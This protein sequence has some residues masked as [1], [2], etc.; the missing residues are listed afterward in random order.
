MKLLSILLEDLRAEYSWPS[1]IPLDG[2]T[3]MF[4]GP[5]EVLDAECKFDADNTVCAATAATVCTMA[6]GCSAPRL[7]HSGSPAQHPAT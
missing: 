6:C 2:L 4:P 3:V 7:E 5:M 1:T